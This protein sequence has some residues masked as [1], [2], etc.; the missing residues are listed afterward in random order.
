MKALIKRYQFTL[1]NLVALQQKYKKNGDQ[2]KRERCLTGMSAYKSII[3]VL[4]DIAERTEYKEPFDALDP[5]FLDK[6]NKWRCSSCNKQMKKKEIN[7]EEWFNNNFD[8]FSDV[9]ERCVLAITKEK[10]L[11][12]LN[13]TK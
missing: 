11:E 3:E 8:Y 12:Y 5:Y 10:F 13:K 2:V 1:D 6:D 7:A 9:N 4:E